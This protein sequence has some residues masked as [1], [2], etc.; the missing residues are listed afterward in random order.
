MPRRS[1]ASL[2]T[3]PINGKP[4][5]LTA[6]ETLTD[7][8][9]ALFDE[10]VGSCSPKH[11]TLSDRSLLVTYVQATLIAQQASQKAATDPKE[12]ARWEKACRVQATLATR[13][14]LS[15]QAR[16]DPKSVLRQQPKDL[17]VPW[18]SP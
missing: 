7:P 2:T 10:I 9:R 18:R 1:F 14:R 6:P 8:E 15:P 5:R 3:L 4:R 11:F 12:L 13:L 17:P 16:S